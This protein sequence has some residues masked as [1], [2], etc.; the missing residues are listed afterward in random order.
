MSTDEIVAVLA[1]ELGHFKL[2]H[3]RWA[4]IRGFFTMGLI[5]FLMSYITS[6]PELYKAFDFDAVT[7]Y[8]T[9]TVFFLWFSLISFLIQPFSSL[10]SRRNEFAADAFAIEN[11]ESKN[12]L[13]KALLKLRENNHSMPISHPLY[14]AFYHSHPPIIERLDAMNYTGQ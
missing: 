8:T 11:I 6:F 1:H 9:L 7:P 14:S 4:L 2:K 12:T 13:G 10:L 5:F 3:I